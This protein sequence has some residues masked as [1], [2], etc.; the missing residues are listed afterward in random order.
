MCLAISCLLDR[1]DNFLVLAFEPFLLDFFDVLV[2]AD[3]FV[4]FI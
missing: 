3:Q 2:A 4:K 1:I